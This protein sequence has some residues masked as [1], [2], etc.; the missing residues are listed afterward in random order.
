[1]SV[2]ERDFLILLFLLPL[3]FLLVPEMHFH[4]TPQKKTSRVGSLTTC[5][6][7]RTQNTR[8]ALC[9]SDVCPGCNERKGKKKGLRHTA[10]RHDQLR[11]QK[12]KGRI[13][14]F[15]QLTATN[16]IGIRSLSIHLDAPVL[17]V[18]MCVVILFS[19]HGGYLNPSF[20]PLIH[21]CIKLFTHSPIRQRRH[22]IWPL[23][24][25]NT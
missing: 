23:A 19:F 24:H 10:R 2:R 22:A 3:V 1:M 21:S 4:S 25:L 12:N 15:P 18:C 13:L 11:R 7:T 16:T 20:R 17:F 14:F 5:T 6:H 8:T 9:Q